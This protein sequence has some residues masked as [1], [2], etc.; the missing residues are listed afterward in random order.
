VPASPNGPVKFSSPKLKRSSASRF[1]ASLRCSSSITGGHDRRAGHDRLRCR[2]WRCGCG[3]TE[4]EVCRH[5]L[6][7]GVEFERIEVDFGRLA[8]HDKA[9]AVPIADILSSEAQ[10]H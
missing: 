8:V 3:T 2:R 10:H 9:L 7:R 1:A 6:P 5:G 4:A